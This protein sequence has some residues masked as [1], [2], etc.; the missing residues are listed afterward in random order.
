MKVLALDKESKVL[1]VQ[2]THDK[3]LSVSYKDGAGKFFI[4]LYRPDSLKLVIKLMFECLQDYDFLRRASA[5]QQ[6]THTLATTEDGK[7]K[8]YNLPGVDG[9]MLK[10]EPAD[11]ITLGP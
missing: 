9:A 5:C 8:F 3:L 2:W 6:I 4:A 7:L 11:E 1:K 10:P